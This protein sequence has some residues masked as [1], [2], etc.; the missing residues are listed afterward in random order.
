MAHTKA[1]M[2]LIPS[3]VPE[4]IEAIADGKMF[5]ASNGVIVVLSKGQDRLTTVKGKTVLARHFDTPISAKWLTR[6][7]EGFAEY[8]KETKMPRG[9]RPKTDQ[10]VIAAPIKRIRM[11]R[12]PATKR[13]T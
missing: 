4:K 12:K 3:K 7:I 6:R 13:T 1:L 8:V 2:D 5:V 10:E 9:P 11:R